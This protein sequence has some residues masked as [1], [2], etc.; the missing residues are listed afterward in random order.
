MLLFLVADFVWPF[1]S[2][3]INIAADFTATTYW[4]IMLSSMNI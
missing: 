4:R 2:L 1:L 3:E